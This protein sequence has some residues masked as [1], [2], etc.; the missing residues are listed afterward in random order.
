[1]RK[2]IWRFAR[3]K[4]PIT[5]RLPWWLVTVKVIL[6]PLEFFYWYM[7]RHTG[8]QICI[9]AWKIDGVVY[10]SETLEE[11]ANGNGKLFRIKRIDGYVTVSEVRE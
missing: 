3:S 8:Y 11:L 9:D 5:D 7:N 4:Y 6:F 2:R 10:S 1:M